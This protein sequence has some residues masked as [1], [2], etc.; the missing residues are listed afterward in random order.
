[1]RRKMDGLPGAATALVLSLPARAVGARPTAA[2][3]GA[4]GADVGTTTTGAG[5]TTIRGAW[6]GVVWTLAPDVFMARDSAEAAS[7]A[8]DFSASSTSGSGGKGGV[9]PRDTES[10]SGSGKWDVTVVRKISVSTGAGF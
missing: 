2:F 3:F 10:V 7:T 8:V 6:P 1:M 4:A 5:F 9:P